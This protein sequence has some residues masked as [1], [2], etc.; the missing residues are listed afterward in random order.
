MC[1]SEIGLFS[2]IRLLC[3]H[4]PFSIF[5]C[6]F[7]SFFWQLSALTGNLSKPTGENLQGAVMVEPAAVL[8]GDK[9]KDPV[10]FTHAHMYESKP[11]CLWLRSSNICSICMY[12]CDSV[13][14]AVW[15]WR[16]WEEQRATETG[17]T[18]TG[19]QEEWPLRETLIS[20]R[21]KTEEYEWIMSVYAFITNSCTHTCFL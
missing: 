5:M 2:D 12:Y 7:F 10:I 6:V 11:L 18:S 3:C 9:G 20:E 13:K 1:G 17:N 16:G 15:G 19:A 8:R 14:D 4:R 21:D